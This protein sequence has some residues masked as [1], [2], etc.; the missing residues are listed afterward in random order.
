MTK[1]VR[2]NAINLLG[3][4]DFDSVLPNLPEGWRWRIGNGTFYGVSIALQRKSGILWLNKSECDSEVSES[5]IIR[6]ARYCLFKAEDRISGG[7]I[8]G[9]VGEEKK[10]EPDERILMKVTSVVDVYRLRRALNSFHD[11]MQNDNVNVVEF[12][13]NFVISAVIMFRNESDASRNLGFLSQ[14][15]PETNW[16]RL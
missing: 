9:V 3:S 1:I 12:D 15:F 4:L 16:T 13:G 7:E 2:G 8:S 11:I 10:K 5:E 14:A 6:S